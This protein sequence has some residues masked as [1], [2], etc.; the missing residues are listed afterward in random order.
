M[1]DLEKLQK[2]FISDTDLRGEFVDSYKRY[3]TNWFN[4]RNNGS[5]THQPNSAI[6]GKKL[7]TSDAR[8]EALRKW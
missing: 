5:T 6:G 1:V 7:G 4:K 2:E 8:V 3:F